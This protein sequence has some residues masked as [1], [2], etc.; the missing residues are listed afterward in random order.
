MPN[1]TLRKVRKNP[2]F[3]A[4]TRWCEE[5]GLSWELHSPTG[6]GH[7]F[8]TIT[9]GAVQIRKTISLT[10]SPCMNANRAVRSTKRKWDAARGKST[11]PDRRR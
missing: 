7:P 3:Q 8:L 11:V 9:D 1:M 4:I 2:D 5:A 6:K 10:P